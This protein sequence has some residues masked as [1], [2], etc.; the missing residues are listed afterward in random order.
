MTEQ[1][2]RHPRPGFWRFLEDLRTGTDRRSGGDRRESERRNGDRPQ[3]RNRR[4]LDRRAVPDRRRRLFETFDDDDTVEIRA[5]VDDP[6]RSALC[7]RCDARL[8]RA[9]GSNHRTIV[10]CTGCHARVE[11]HSDG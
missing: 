11:L 9:S 1:A 4:S 7:P 2:P 3:G 6:T 10:V 8:L 5:I